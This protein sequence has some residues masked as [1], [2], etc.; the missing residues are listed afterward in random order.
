MT[1]R[2]LIPVLLLTLAIAAALTGRSAAPKPSALARGPMI[3]ITS[4]MRGDQGTFG[5]HYARAVRE[6]GGVP[7]IV[8]ILDDADAALRAEYVRRLDGLVLIGGRDV[9]PAAYGRQPHETVK[10]MPPARWRFESKLA[11]A[12]LKTEKP[13]LG[14]CLGLQTVNVVT[15]GTLVQDIPSQIGVKVAHRKKG[16]HTSHKVTVEPDSRLGRLLEARQIEVLSSHHQAAERTGKN[17]RVVARGADGV[18][19]AME[20][21]GPRWLVLVQW[22]PERM[23]KAHR[24]AIYGALVRACRAKEQ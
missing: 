21:T 23:G 9:P 17:L 5:L 15:G 12:W 3:G 11:A 10:V 2:I 19:E 7:V 1:K 6:A 4:T 13:I 14:V 24:S 18:V 22:H 16:G 20:A 8:P